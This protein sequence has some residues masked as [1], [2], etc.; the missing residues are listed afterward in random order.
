MN[1]ECFWNYSELS[2]KCHVPP[3]V[4]LLPR[5]CDALDKNR[6]VARWNDLFHQF[7]DVSSCHSD[8]SRR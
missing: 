8:Q 2:L 7:L 3:S 1:F 6:L 5:S 4:Y